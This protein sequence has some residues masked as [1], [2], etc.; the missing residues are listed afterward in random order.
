VEVIAFLRFTFRG[1]A[2]PRGSMADLSL[3]CT[4][5]SSQSQFQFLIFV[6]LNAQFHRIHQRGRSLATHDM[7]TSSSDVT[8]NVEC[9]FGK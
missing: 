6:V 8:A 4:I 5:F 9:A 7:T 1:Q 3:G 2:Q